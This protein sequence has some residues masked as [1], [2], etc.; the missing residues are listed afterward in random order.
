MK[1][2]VFIPPRKVINLSNNNVY[3]S[4]SDAGRDLSVRSSTITLR[5]QNK[6]TFLRYLD[7]SNELTKDQQDDLYNKYKIG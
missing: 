7:D 2:K 5:C 3:E 6:H 4:C 1:E